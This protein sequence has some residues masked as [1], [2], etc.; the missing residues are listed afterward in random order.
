[1]SW[2]LD[3]ERLPSP[4]LQ[5]RLDGV[6]E[7]ANAAAQKLLGRS[8]AEIREGGIERLLTGAGRMLYHTQLIPSVRQSGQAVGVTLMMVDAAGSE[9]RVL[10]QAS[11]VADDGDD[12]MTLVLA[13]ARAGVA[14]EE[15]LLRMG[16]AAD[17]SPGMLFEYLIDSHG[18][19]RFGYA[20]AAIVD[21]FGLVPEQVRLDDTPLRLRVHP[22]DL[23]LLI[24]A[25]DRSAL[26]RVLWSMRFRAHA[27]EDRPWA[28]LALRA[29]PRSLADGG[30]AWHGFVEDVTRQRDMEFAERERTAEQ[31][32]E[33][34]RREADQIIR[35]VTESIPGRV[36]YFDVACVCRFANDRFRKWVSLPDWQSIGATISEVFGQARTETL[37][38]PIE[39]A[40]AGSAQQC[41]LHEHAPGGAASWSLVH[42][43][44]DLRGG[45]VFGVVMLGTDVTTIKRSEQ[46]LRELNDQLAS[47]L[48]QAEAA[49]RSKSAFLANMSHEIRTPMNAIIGLTHLLARDSLD[50]VQRERLGKVGDASQHLLKIINDVLDLSK[51]EAG[52]MD[53]EDIEFNV[54]ALLTGAFDLVRE[55]AREKG[56][57]LVL[58]SHSLPGH[59]RGD[60]TRLSQA[61]LNLLS[62]AVKFTGH[63][64]IRVRAVVMQQ[65]RTRTLVRFEVTDTGEGIAAEHQAKIFSNFEQADTSTTRRHGGTGLGLAI[66]R[67]LASL[68]GGDVGLLSV[69]GDGSTFWFSAWLGRAAEAAN[70]AVPLDMRGLR[71]MVVDDLA[72]ASAVVENRLV[73]FGFE[74]HSFNSGETALAHVHD[75]LRSGRSYDVVLVDRQMAP[76]DGLGTIAALR[77]LLGDGM[78]PC[79]LVTAFD[80]PDVRRPPISSNFD[81][82]L[83][84]P[85]TASSLNDALTR[86][87]RPRGTSLLAIAESTQSNELA[88][89]RQHAGKR[90]L[91]AEDNPINQVVACVLMRLAGLVV[92][93]A[94]DGLRA[95]EM[96]STRDFDLILMDMQMPRLDG[97]DATRLIRK[98]LGLAKPVI[99]MTANAFAEERTACLQ[100]G[101]ND[102]ISKPVDPEKLYATLLRWLPHASASVLSSPVADGDQSSLIAR[103]GKVEGL[104]VGVGL[105]NV[106]GS[107]SLFERTLRQFAATY[108]QGAPE[109]GGRAT[110]HERE[111]ASRAG[112]SLRG[113][114]ATIGASSLS[115]SLVELEAALRGSGGEASIAA[116]SA[117]AQDQLRAL[118]QSLDAVLGSM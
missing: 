7:H 106:G 91:L 73:A 3:P 21:L 1:M 68:M 93:T 65:E 15:Q 35:L 90:V 81:A 16:R 85:V 49:T 98:K 75:E 40:L 51:I 64:W 89:R 77:L 59:L 111:Q 103:L 72:E 107:A 38:R 62:N 39:Q 110:P 63:G 102:H 8:Q 6:V 5:V 67:H 113:S 44:P 20:S 19:G 79:V 60:P 52:K 87:L 84:K 71:A 36:A 25:R 50:T 42:L 43:F 12:V 83:V 47:A 105:R 18:R 104:D 37:R 97:I 45:Q 56:L 118:I 96:A 14:S 92:E 9:V 31:R 101:M 22:Q 26:A 70:L 66:T 48:E 117:Q 4:V 11:L 76:M 24:E 61:L 10:A 82:V 34:V 32:A 88:L 99:A 115:S 13:P 100:A 86:L 95:V 23:P 69:K 17:A 2:A 109:L 55:R 94:E 57:E 30:T 33:S 58:D 28:W 80:D 108:A 53:L 27:A 112:H 41:E 46:Q 74:V 29:A 116:L 78:P 54:D 114:S